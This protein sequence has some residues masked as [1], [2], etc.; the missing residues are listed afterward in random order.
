MIHIPLKLLDFYLFIYIYKERT[1]ISHMMDDVY[2][3]LIG[4][5]FEVI[6]VQKCLYEMDKFNQMS[7]TVDN[8]SF[9]RV[10]SSLFPW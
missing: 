5:K 6:H 4:V 1:Y 3:I 10:T 2:I 7:P 9:S 8:Y